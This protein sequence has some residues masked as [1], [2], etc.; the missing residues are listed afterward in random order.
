MPT[1]QSPGKG[2]D[3]LRILI[4][5]TTYAPYANGQAVFTTNLAENLASVGH[6]VAVATHATDGRESVTQRNGVSVYTPTSYNLGVIHPDAEITLNAY[7][8]VERLFEDFQP[9]VVHLHDHFPLSWFVWWAA[10]RR[11]LPVIGADHFMP[12][13]HAPYLPKWQQYQ[14]IYRPAL[15]N[16]MLLLYN[17]L[18]CVIVQSAYA[19]ALLRNA[20]LRPPM[21]RIT[22]GIDLTHFYCDPTIDRQAVRAR[23]G[24]S[25][26]RAVVLYLGRL[27]KEKRIDLLLTALH[28]W[29]SDDVQ[30]A[31]AGRGVAMESM[32]RLADRLALGDKVRF[33]GYIAREDVRPLL[34]SADIF[35][36]PSPAEL[37]SIATLEAMACGRPI[38]AARAGALPELVVEGENGRL[39]R[40]DDAEDAARSLAQLVEE[41]H[42][43]QEMGE[44][45]R[46]R[47]AAHSW[48]DALRSHEALYLGLS[49]SPRAVSQ[50]NRSWYRPPG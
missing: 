32:M 21:V 30:L 42:L 40:A 44:R 12:E 6:Q 5:T 22:C 18:D 2:A 34:N 48:P 15:W 4:A 24:L 16:L 36:M 20:G 47:A 41:S 11:G 46:Q 23:F 13:N 31:I 35:A 29:G 8:A 7:G 10:R 39:F 45:S 1:V 28:R 38:L 19:G 49:A 14:A 33:L 17:R 25:S 9:Q 50:S 37:L 27:D 3:L 43:W 26:P